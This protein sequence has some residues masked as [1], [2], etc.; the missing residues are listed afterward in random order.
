M[1]ILIALTYY[2]PYISGFT[3]YAVR[4]AGALA[5][6][7]HA[8][9][10]LT[11]R[12]D[13]AL[14]LHETLDGVEVVRV[15]VAAR[16]SKAVVM[17]GLLFRAAKLIRQADVVNLHLP[18]M[19][20]A[21]LALLS[22]LLGKPVVITY[23]CDLHLPPGLVNWA[24]DRASLISNRLVCRAA[25]LVTAMSQDYA[26]HSPVLKR[27]GSKVV[28]VDAPVSL[29]AVTPADV[30][31]FRR[32]WNIQPGQPVIGMVARLAAEKGVEYLVAALPMVLARYPQA[33]VLYVGQHEDVLGEEAYARRLAPQIAALGTHW[34][35]LGNISYPELAAF[36]R[37]CAVTVL[38]SLNSTEAFGMVQVESMLSGTPA[39]GTDL[40]GVRVPVQSTGMGK[41]VPP[42][43]A[44]A[45][46][47]AILEILDHKDRFSG[48]LVQ[49]R[50]RFD[51]QTTA[52]NY[53]AIFQ[54]VINPL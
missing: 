32:R 4:L 38:P 51:P 2:S 18:Q 39:V 33:R 29:P 28:P 22:R 6:R 16:V 36:Y 30:E 24:A 46:A 10:V 5:A 20:G 8:V 1:R 41:I 31:V 14:P 21:P 35:F 15:P 48:D 44:P 54:K 19:D 7:G 47:G 53:E 23:I 43:D 37:A 49:V 52:A 9:T 40:P 26:D 13:P 34:S 12:F 45:L 50:Q 3:L 17:P 11:S 25:N 42:G 27:L